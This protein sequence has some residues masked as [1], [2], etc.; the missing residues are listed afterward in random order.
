MIG[1]GGSSAG[2]KLDR[3]IHGVF[4]EGGDDYFCV[5]TIGRKDPPKV[6]VQGR[7]L[8]CRVKVGGQSVRFDGEKIVFGT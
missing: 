6:T 8:D 2:K 4:A 1:G 3:P 7:G 5:V